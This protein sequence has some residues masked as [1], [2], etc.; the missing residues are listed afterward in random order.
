MLYHL[1]IVSIFNCLYSNGIIIIFLELVKKYLS[2][3]M[4]ENIKLNV[5]Q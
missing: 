5:K 1:F 4:G 3:L 2:V